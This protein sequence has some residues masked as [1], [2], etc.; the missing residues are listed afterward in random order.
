M[1]HICY[2][3]S[4]GDWTCIVY[5]SS[6]QRYKGGNGFSISILDL[7]F[8]TNS[9]YGCGGKGG[10]SYQR[11][12]QS[13]SWAKELREGANGGQGLVVLLYYK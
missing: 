5:G 12:Y 13:G 1:D 2:G 11:Q 3:G 6:T 8:N 10:E 4:P 9:G 7:N